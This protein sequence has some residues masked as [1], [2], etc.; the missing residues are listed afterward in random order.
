[1]RFLAAALAWSTLCAASAVSTVVIP[2]GTKITLATRNDLSSKKSAKGDVVDL[3]L[4]D[5]LSI[6]GVTVLPAGTLAVGEITDSRQTGGLGSN[7]KLAITPL[8]IRVGDTVVRLEGHRDAKGRT[9][10]DTVAGLA[11]VT[12]VISGRTAVIDANTRIDAVTIRPVAVP[13]SA[14]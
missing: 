9:G 10:V 11:L 13:L 7:G 1:V 5:G 8:Y 14:R 6:D 3:Y 4:P 12:A 2:A